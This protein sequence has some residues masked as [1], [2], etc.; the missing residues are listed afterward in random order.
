MVFPSYPN[1]GAESAATLSMITNVAFVMT[2]LGIIYTTI[3]YKPIGRLRDIGT[4]FL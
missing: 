2:V 3:E 4:M 1:I